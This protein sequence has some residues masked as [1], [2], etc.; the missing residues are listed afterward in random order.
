VAALQLRQG[1]ARK[2]AASQAGNLPQNQGVAL[3]LAAH[4]RRGALPGVAAG[5]AAFHA[6]QSGQDQGRAE[7]RGQPE[8]QARAQGWVEGG[9]LAAGRADALG[10]G[11][12]MALFGFGQALVNFAQ[13]RVGFSGGQMA[14]DMRAV[15][16]IQVVFDQRGKGQGSVHGSTSSGKNLGTPLILPAVGAGGV[17]KGV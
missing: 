14:V 10:P 4:G 7:A 16:F 1:A 3:L 13:A 8:Q 15:A 5:A 9:H 2:P 11:R 17:K 12:G 6:L